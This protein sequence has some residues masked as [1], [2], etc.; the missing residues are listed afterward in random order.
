[1]TSIQGV[2]LK[3]IHI[4]A[5]YGLGTETGRFLTELSEMESSAHIVGL[6]DGFRTSGELYG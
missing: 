4:I 6:L 2:S 5:I 1:M 3:Q